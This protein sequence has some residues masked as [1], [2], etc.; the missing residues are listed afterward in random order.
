MARTPLENAAKTMGVGPEMEDRSR[1]DA[2]PTEP[3]AQRSSP[4]DVTDNSEQGNLTNSQGVL[5]RLDDLSEEQRKAILNENFSSWRSWAPTHLV[6]PLSLPFSLA[7]HIIF[8]MYPKF[9]TDWHSSTR[10]NG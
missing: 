9:C 10:A 1:E 7:S 4:E 3:Q 5:P 6:R 8:G 2:P